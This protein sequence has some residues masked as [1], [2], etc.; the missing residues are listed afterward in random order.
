[1]VPG[2]DQY[3]VSPHNPAGWGVFFE[4]IHV[5]L[6]GPVG[7]LLAPTTQQNSRLQSKQSHLWSPHTIFHLD[8][9]YVLDLLS[10]VALP[11]TNLALTILL[12]DFFHYLQSNSYVELRKV[13]SH[14]GITGNDREDSNASLI[15]TLSHW[16]FLLPVSIP[17]TLPPDP[18]T[19]SF[20]QTIS[21]NADNCFPPIQATSSSQT[22]HLH[23]YHF[24]H[25]TAPHFSTW[26]SKV[27]P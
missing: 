25:W 17:P 13:K 15:P 20:V 18:T 27:S 16:T 19:F 7:S 9:Q 8:S 22:I 3:N 26:H 24:P 14:T 5:D 12:L 11:C 4:S 21:T 1:M 6:Y 23:R 2:S 10:G